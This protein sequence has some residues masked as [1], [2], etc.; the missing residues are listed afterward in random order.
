MHDIPNAD[1]E[2]RKKSE[3]LKCNVL[4]LPCISITHCLTNWTPNTEVILRVELH[5]SSESQAF[6]GELIFTVH[7]V[8]KRPATTY[9]DNEQHLME[10]VS[11]EITQKMNVLPH[12]IS[13]AE[14][15]VS[16]AST[17]EPRLSISVSD[18]KVRPAVPGC[19]S[20]T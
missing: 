9:P 15:W 2:N 8:N 11:K 14:F 6:T 7:S 16:N 13:L 3:T 18:V 12:L 5:S 4:S 10:A 17:R 19:I 20:V 1:A